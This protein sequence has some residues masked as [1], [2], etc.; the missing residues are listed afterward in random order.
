MAL[1]APGTA[2]RLVE[3]AAKPVVRVV[4]H[5]G[6]VAVPGV[7]TVARAVPGAVPVA[8]AVARVAVIL[9]PGGKE[10]DLMSKKIFSLV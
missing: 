8:G 7:V 4:W 1:G 3:I 6:V 10:T 9:V 5:G 2:R